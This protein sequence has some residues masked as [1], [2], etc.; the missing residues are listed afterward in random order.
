M[1][2]LVQFQNALS[3]RR[4][5]V[6][7]ELRARPIMDHTG[8]PL[9]V[10]GNNALV[11]RLRRTDG[12]NTALRI[13]ASEG[14]DKEWSVRYAGLQALDSASLAEVMPGRIRIVKHGLA[15]EAPA[16]PDDFPD[17]GPAIAMEWIE[18]P[19]LIEAVDRAARAGNT[20]VLKALATAVVDFVNTLCSASFVHGDLTASNLI[21]RKDG[22]LAVVDLDTAS[23]ANSP[24]GSSG[25]GSP[26]YRHPRESSVAAMRDLFALLTI[27]TSLRVLAEDPDLRRTYGDPISA[28]DGVLLFSAWDLHDPSNSRC[29]LDV[30]ERVDS[31]TRQIVDSLQSACVHPLDDLASHL[32]VMPRLN[33][34]AALSQPAQAH[35]AGWNL[36]TAVNRIRTRYSGTPSKSTGNTGNSSAELEDTRINP[37]LGDWGRDNSWATW[38]T[39]ADIPQPV[40]G[41]DVTDEDRTRL[42]IALDRNNEP[43]IA[44]LW[45][46][47]KDDPIVSIQGGRVEAALVA[48]YQRR[49]TEESTRGR[50]RA[51]VGLAEEAAA[52]L[53]PLGSECRT[54]VRA[55]R[56]RLEV[57]A[58]L[59]EALARNDRIQLAELA[60]SGKLVVLGDTDRSSLH[61]VLRA[62]EWPALQ[63]A[64]QSDDDHLILGA[65]DPELFSEMSD[66]DNG[67]RERIH[68]AERR[69]DWLTQVRTALKKRQVQDLG[70]LFA[71]PPEGGTE[72]LST[73]ERRRI[74]QSIE[75]RVALEELGNVIR[76]EDDAAIIAA[77]NRVERVGARVSDRFAWGVIQ[78]VVERV[79][80]IE[81]LI[82]AAESTP[83][84]YGRL[85]QLLPVVRALGLARDTRLQGDHAI[86]RLEAHVVRIAHVRRI[87]AAIGRDNDVAIMVAAVPDPHGALDD[88]T[89]E[90]RDRVAAAILSRRQVDRNSVQERI[91]R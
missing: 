2:R 78:R 67:V 68:L 83:I 54:L 76:S 51:V 28:C 64:I 15:L 65:F 63:R 12:S 91:A 36:D 88:L 81:D 24:L 53:L 35:A 86:E 69:V 84:D 25:T 27:Y 14:N 57:R 45:A 85:A 52:R 50:D 89:E 23:W 49:V 40:A 80:V 66:L 38:D 55:A 5:P 3:D 11:A 4:V 46:R 72:R 48:G 90:E 7:L 31:G 1:D 87:R 60:V 10:A 43:E 30:N 22:R 44:R 42:M 74:R 71:E 77:L 16:N 6:L 13:V 19:T 32:G 37:T 20:N 75:R 39:T 26:G 29:F 8:K 56:E 18:G 62:I 21:V 47:L 33:L 41:D 73:P 58:S 82:E 34:P 61:R 9:V 17:P 70:R 59:E 79:S